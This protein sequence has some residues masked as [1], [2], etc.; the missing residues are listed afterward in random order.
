MG[1]GAEAND[2]ELAL[3]SE[4]RR[5]EARL[6]SLQRG[7]DEIVAYS[8]GTPPDDEHDPEGATV[9]W[10]RGQL[11]A[12]RAQAEAHLAE[13]AAARQRLEEGTYGVCERCSRPI[14]APRLAARPATRLCMACASRPN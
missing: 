5:T 12:L 10:E 1:N 11:S 7:F 9:A 13:I 4:Q 6:A 8:D 3:A 14:E 2:P